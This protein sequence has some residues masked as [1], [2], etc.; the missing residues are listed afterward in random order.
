M[1]KLFHIAGLAALLCASFATQAA[2]Q[3]FAYSYTFSG[4]AGGGEVTGAFDGLAD[5]NLVTDLANVTAYY[6]GVAFNSSGSLSVFSGISGSNA[7]ASFD[8]LQNNFIFVDSPSSSMDTYT[9]RFISIDM[10]TPDS[11]IGPTSY[12]MVVERPFA[13]PQLILDDNYP[14]NPS[15][16]FAARWSLT[17]SAVPE[18]ES[19]AL[20]LAGLGLM[21]VIARR[22]G[23]FAPQT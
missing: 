4:A 19:Y 8:G 5:G 14:G 2:S 6:D 13:Q 10:D 16:Y 9:N 17:V 11:P 7:T 20:L 15:Q 12:V 18:P 1:K 3:H 22:R 23:G 21:G